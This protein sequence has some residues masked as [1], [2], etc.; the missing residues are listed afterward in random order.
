MR[1]IIPSACSSH[2]KE[3]SSQKEGRRG[4]GLPNSAGNFLHKYY[5][6]SL[7]FIHD[8]NIITAYLNSKTEGEI[9]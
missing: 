8:G 6:I 2:R 1:P 9:K 7:F 4:V 3:V 5:L